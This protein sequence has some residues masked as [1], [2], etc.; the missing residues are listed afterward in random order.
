VKVPIDRGTLSFR[1]EGRPDQKTDFLST[2]P[3]TFQ[4]GQHPLH[5]GRARSEPVQAVRR[6]SV[7]HSGPIF[8]GPNSGIFWKSYNFCDSNTGIVCKW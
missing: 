1:E 2:L 5:E 8:C 3:S 6:Q 4:F 7:H